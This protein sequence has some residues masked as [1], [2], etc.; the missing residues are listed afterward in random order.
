MVNGDN[1]KIFAII[2][3]AIFIVLGLLFLTQG[4]V[5]NNFLM[6]A[7]SVIAILFGTIN[8]VALDE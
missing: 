4:F 8:L 5:T 1:M 6:A 7:V 3:N 2:L